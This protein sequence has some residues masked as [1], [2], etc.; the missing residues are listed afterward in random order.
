VVFAV[1]AI[2]FRK[3]RIHRKQANAADAST[4][5]KANPIRLGMIFRSNLPEG[6]GGLVQLTPS[7]PK[8]CQTVSVAPRYRQVQMLCCK[9]TL[10]LHI[11]GV[12]YER[13]GLEPQNLLLKLRLVAGF[14]V[15][16]L[17]SHRVELGLT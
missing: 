13:T 9:Q 5:N 6:L 8:G 7:G 11:A 1:I 16:D 3:Q 14:G 10:R 17:R 12:S 4:I 2:Y 15:A